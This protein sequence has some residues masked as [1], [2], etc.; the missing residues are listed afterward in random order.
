MYEY[1]YLVAGRDSVVGIATHCGVVGVRIESRWGQ[2]LRNRSDRSWGPSSLLN[3]GYR[4]SFSGVKRPR[5]GVNHP[6]RSSVEIKERV[7][8]LYV[9][10][11][12]L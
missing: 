2:D 12:P 6:P 11:G 8:L 9:P 4:V 7:E 10:S 1:T 3:N 5:S